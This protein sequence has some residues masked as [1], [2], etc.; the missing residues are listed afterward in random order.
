MTREWIQMNFPNLIDHIIIG[1]FMGDSG[2]RL[3]KQDML[4][5]IHADVFIDDNYGYVHDVPLLLC[6]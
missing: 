3:S 1:N 5:Q 2:V 6:T 4:K